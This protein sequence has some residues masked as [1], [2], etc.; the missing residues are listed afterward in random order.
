MNRNKPKRKDTPLG[1]RL[2]V[3]E[4]L[5]FGVCD[6]GGNLFFTVIGFYLLIFLTDSVGLPAAVAGTALMIGKIWDA[7][8]DP[9]VGYLSDR[10]RSRWG[11]RRP[12]LL[13]GSFA[14]WASMILLFTSPAGTVGEGN[15]SGVFIW[16]CL[17]FCL[18]NTALTVVN[19]PYGA[20]T[21]E[22]TPDYHE[23]TVLNGYRM[24][25]A[26]VGTFIGA[27]LVLP[28]VGLA[29]TERAGWSLMGAV[30]GGIMAG[31]ALITFF[32][33]K[34]RFRADEADTNGSTPDKA[35]GLEKDSSAEGP[36]IK[37]DR[38]SEGVLQSYLSALR[39]K[40]FLLALVPWTLHIT[41]VT[42]IQ[43]ALLYYYRYIFR[44]ES[45]F[46][47]AL[48]VLLLAAL[49]AIP[50]WVW[51]AKRIGKKL[52]WNIG[53]AIF[54]TVI[55]LFFFFGETAGV[56]AS[57]YFLAA[58][59]IGFSTHYVMPFA[60]LPDV[61]EYDADRNGVRREGVFY[62]LWTFV[63]KLGQAI[64]LLV[65]GWVLDIFGYVPAAVQTPSAEFGIRFLVGP[66]PALLFVGGILT[67]SFYPITRRV[68]ESLVKEK[69]HE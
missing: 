69:P 50:L 35:S 67:L 1:P 26:I 9:A 3:K 59:G 12:Y 53:M 41:G 29:E 16:A 30:T 37:G 6:L 27:A 61:V 11:R 48:L 15:I 21:P 64:A 55:L 54:A 25:F 62:G 34:E 58:A 31:T 14:L 28:I 38:P 63:S 44:E 56:G 23:R 13:F 18:A 32:T 24:S 66:V 52:V 57:Y 8:T 2:G 45:A 68:Y 20:L 4:K 22:L 60:I 65:S 5:G 33:V 10:T 39:E 17:S 19:I 36:P 40:P 46:Q 7:V 51:A 47:L 49:L 43:S 42:V